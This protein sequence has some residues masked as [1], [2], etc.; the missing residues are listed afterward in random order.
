MVLNIYMDERVKI[1]TI[2]RLNDAIR[3]L[4][5]EIIRLLTVLEECLESGNCSTEL[6]DEIMREIG[7]LKDVIYEYTVQ[8]EELLKVKIR[9]MSKSEGHL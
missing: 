5:A 6:I 3:Y 4:E 7:I 9:E 2:R 1:D 8:L